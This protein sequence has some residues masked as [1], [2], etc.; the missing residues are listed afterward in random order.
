MIKLRMEKLWDKFRFAWYFIEYCLAVIVSP[1]FKKKEDFR[2]LWIIAE[3][4]IDA[5][6][7]GYHLFRYISK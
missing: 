2:H 7:N 4:G 5:G 1:F 6:D 3:R